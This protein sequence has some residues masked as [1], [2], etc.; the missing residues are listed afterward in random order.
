MNAMIDHPSPN[1]GTRRGGGRIDM[2]ILHYTGMPTGTQALARLCDRDA[3]VS[4]HYLVEEDG[5]V[6]RLVAEE[7]RAWHAGVSAWGETRDVNSHS[8]GIEIVN[9]G[10]EWGY[11]PFPEPQLA[12]VETLLA[13]VL[14]RH[15]VPLTRVL[16]HSDVAPARKEDPGELFPWQRLARKGLALWPEVAAG[17]GVTLASGDAGAAVAAYRAALARFGYPLEP[18]DRF[19]ATT[20]TVTRAVQRHFA[21]QAIGTAR[22]GCADADLQ[23]LARALGAMVP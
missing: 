18:G 1:Y 15:A 19:D 22:E 23:A 9:P 17:S 2:V 14:A 21:P 10:H 3:E 13:G 4:A 5:R 8:I 12:A 20:A 7:Q 6:F 11:R 16:G